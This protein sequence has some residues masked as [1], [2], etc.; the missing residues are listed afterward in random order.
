[1]HPSSDLLPVLVIPL[2]RSFYGIPLSLIHRVEQKEETST[3]RER[4]IPFARYLGVEE[5]EEKKREYHILLKEKREV[6]FLSFERPM[7][8]I[9]EATQLKSLPSL[10]V[11]PLIE[12]V[13]LFQPSPSA[14]MEFLFIVRL[15]L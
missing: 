13:A 10:L 4:Y 2:Q 1:M 7:R 15:I 12:K 11:H 3:N 5:P 14:E 8:H 9:I 6:V